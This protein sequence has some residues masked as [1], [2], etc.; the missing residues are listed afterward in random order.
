MA[1]NDFASLWKD[2]Q[3]RYAEASGKDL[4]DLEMPRTTEDLIKGITKQNE[5]YGEFRKKQV[6]EI[7]SIYSSCARFPVTDRFFRAPCSQ[8]S[9]PP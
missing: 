5:K 9:K 6:G 1:K 2:A 7:L 3:D 4:K 8:S